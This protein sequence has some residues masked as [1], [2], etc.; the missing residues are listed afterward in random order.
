MKATCIYCGKPFDLYPGWL[1]DGMECDYCR[2][3]ADDRDDNDNDDENQ[4]EQS[5]EQN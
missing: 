5:D 3:Y 1:A 4:E 2:A